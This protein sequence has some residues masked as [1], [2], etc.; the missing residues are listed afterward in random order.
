M[1]KAASGTTER[2]DYAE[3]FKPDELVNI[4]VKARGKDVM[5]IRVREKCSWAD[6]LVLCSGKSPRHISDLMIGHAV[7]FEYKKRVA[8]NPNQ[9]VQ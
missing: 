9:T 6:W 7:M 8:E 4:L 2:M 3:M 1:T 5:A